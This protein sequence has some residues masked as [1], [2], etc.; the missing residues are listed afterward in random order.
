MRGVARLWLCS[1]VVFAAVPAQAAVPTARAFIQRY[2]DASGGQ[3]ALD[4]DTVLHVTGRVTDA[5]MKGSFE[6]W[7]QAPGRALRVERMGTLR[8]R[9]GI[10]G[11]SAWRTDY[12][13][14]RVNPVEGKDLE[15]M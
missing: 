8:T 11:A 9:Q 6:A 1:L 5:G 4:A 7:I 13:N 12:T 10:D 14:K 15:A 3:A 2:V